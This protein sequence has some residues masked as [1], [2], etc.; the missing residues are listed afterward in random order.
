MAKASKKAPQRA[1]LDLLMDGLFDAAVEHGWRKLTLETIAEAAKVDI[2]IARRN[3]TSAIDLLG[4]AIRR[5]DRLALNEISAF[6]EEDSVRDRLFAL[7]MARFDAMTPH[8]EGVRVILRDGRFDPALHMTVATQGLCSMSRMLEAAG[9]TATGPVGM[10]RAKGL[11]LVNANAVRIWLEDES[12]D[13]GKTMA[14]L[15][16]GLAQAES[17]ARTFDPTVRRRGATKEPENQT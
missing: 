5:A 10:A 8:R 12:E 17:L 14:V 15:D 4:H 16:K 7:L 1:P 2:K 9:L 11:A 6:D 13:L 3:A